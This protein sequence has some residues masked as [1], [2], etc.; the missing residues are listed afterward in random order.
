MIKA[1]ED[2]NI[3]TQRGVQGLFPTPV[4]VSKLPFELSAEEKKELLGYETKKN[5]GNLVT[6]ESYILKKN[7]KLKRLNKW[8]LNEIKFY[9][10]QILCPAFDVSLYITQS[11]ITFTIQNVA[12]HK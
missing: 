1:I 12:I 8:F 11:W 4:Q 7:K 3:S 6:K 5:E 10:D 2:Y 9:Q